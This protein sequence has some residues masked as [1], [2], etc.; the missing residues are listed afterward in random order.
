MCQLPGEKSFE[1]PKDIRVESLREILV[2]KK[3]YYER[4]RDKLIENAEKYCATEENPSEILV[5]TC[6]EILR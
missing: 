3:K 4:P 5:I 6:R 2:P 1:G